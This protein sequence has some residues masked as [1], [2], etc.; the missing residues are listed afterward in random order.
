MFGKV[1]TSREPSSSY[2]ALKP[3]KTASALSIAGASGT[4]N[5]SSAH[6][7][8]TSL[9]PSNNIKQ[10]SSSQSSLASLGSDAREKMRNSGKRLSASIQKLTTHKKSSVSIRDPKDFHSE[11]GGLDYMLEFV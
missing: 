4:S 9:A 1:A 8:Q 2:L 6:S 11:V 5:Y 7:S 3:L 10:R